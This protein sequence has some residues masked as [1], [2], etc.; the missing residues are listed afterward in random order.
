M[1]KY[2]NSKTKLSP[3][4]LL[5]KTVYAVTLLLNN[6]V[7]RKPLITILCYHGISSDQWR[8]NLSKDE[9]SRQLE[10]FSK[11]YKFISLADLV[12]FLDGKT[13]IDSPSLVITFDDGY[14]NLMQ[15]TDLAAK[16]HLKPTVFVLSDPKNANRHELDNGQSLLSS[17]QI[18]NLYKQG[19]EIGC[20][21]ATHALMSNLSDDQINIEII[22]SK[23]TLEKKLDISIPY[24]AYPKGGYSE[25]IITAVKKTGY[26]LGLSMD[27]D[28]L[29]KASNRFALPRVGL[30][31][32]FTPIEVQSAILPVSTMFRSILSH[33]PFVKLI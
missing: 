25:K 11:S 27:S 8:F 10:V 4:L 29:T 20:H 12:N 16:Y 6:I 19:W 14:A 2:I 30:D 7:S 22:K 13:S 9:F 23:K 28:L 5:R 15:I 32:S 31:Q 33:T 26:E 18:K 24:I 1:I 17:S 3:G 21:T